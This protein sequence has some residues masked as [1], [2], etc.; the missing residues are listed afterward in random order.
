M[1][2]YIRAKV[3]I[4]IGISNLYV[5]YILMFEGVDCNGCENMAIAMS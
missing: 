5:E 1:I 3:G 4:I 2:G